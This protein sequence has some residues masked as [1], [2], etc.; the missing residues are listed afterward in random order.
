MDGPGTLKALFVYASDIAH[1]SAAIQALCP[2]PPRAAAAVGAA[3][4]IATDIAVTLAVKAA[5]S[6]VDAVAA[7][8]RAETT[9]LDTTVTLDGFF[10]ETGD[11]AAAGGYLMFHTGKA[12][13]DPAGASMT[14]SLRLV[15]SFDRTAFRF[16]VQ[17]WAFKRLLKP[18]HRRWAQDEDTRDFALK[19]EFLSP[20][21]DGLG[22]RA[23][24]IEQTFTG[25]T[26]TQIAGAYSQGQTLP[27][28]AT[29]SK[30][31][32]LPVATPTE[33]PR[34]RYLPLNIRVTVIETTRPNLFAQWVQETATE[35]KG[36]IAAAVKDALKKTLD[37]DYATA[38]TGKLVDAAS[39]AY[40][41]YK[42]AWDA[43]AETQTKAPAPLAADADATA[44]ARHAA[45]TKA[46]QASVTVAKQITE[47]KRT[48]ARSTFAT[49]AL[50]WP[51][52]LPAV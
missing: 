32:G 42:K 31:G 46:W 47:G 21:S 36:D 15:P 26:A 7:K 51:G 40:A 13:D 1:R 34:A 8:T 38:E 11:I 52:D 24:F 50:V 4:A 14:M 9:T 43:L 27:W 48:L 49:A 23:V 16:E 17:H 33:D 30:P 37:S 12:P 39:N 10:T 18:D 2:P 25:V 5:Q 41:E 45:E 19:I 3:A 29:P 28:F 22:N 20:G 35:K 44:K 6:L